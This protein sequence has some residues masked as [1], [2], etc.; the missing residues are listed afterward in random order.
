MNMKRSEQQIDQIFHDQLEGY[1]LSPPPGT[2]ENIRGRLKN[3]KRKQRIVLLRAI[4]AAAVIILAMVAGW[5]LYDFP[6]SQ[7]EMSENRTEKIFPAATEPVSRDNKQDVTKKEISGSDLSENK[8]VPAEKPR[9]G[10]LICNP[11]I[12]V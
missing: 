7:Q 12:L 9:T 4:A 3:R 10:F 6:E 2:L 1:T 11:S 5:M 8:L